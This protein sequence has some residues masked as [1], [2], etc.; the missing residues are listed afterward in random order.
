MSAITI[1]TLSEYTEALRTFQQASS[2]WYGLDLSH[3]YSATPRGWYE[4][5]DNAQGGLDVSWAFHREASDEE[6]AEQYNAL[7]EELRE[8]LDDAEEE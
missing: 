4:S 1:P 6:I 7:C 5:T 2:G 3:F 8:S